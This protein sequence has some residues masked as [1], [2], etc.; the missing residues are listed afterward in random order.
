MRNLT[1]ALDR[2]TVSTL[3]VGGGVTANSRLRREL[4]ALAEQRSLDLRLP[5]IDFCLDNAA[6]IAGLAAI[7]LHA[8][9]IDTLTLS[10]SPR[11][12]LVS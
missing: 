1:K 4:A 9:R 6:M 5:D 8:N 11:T 3:L 7:R 12:A 10:A 2:H